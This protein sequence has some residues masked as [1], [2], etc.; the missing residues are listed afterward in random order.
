MILFFFR[1]ISPS[2]PSLLLSPLSLRTSPFPSLPLSEP[3]PLL[4]TLVG[5]PGPL[6]PPR[7]A[8]THRIV[9]ERIQRRLSLVGTLLSLSFKVLRPDILFCRLHHYMRRH[10]MVRA[11]T[12][13]IVAPYGVYM[14]LPF[15][16]LT[17][18][19][20]KI[21]SSS[22]QTEPPKKYARSFFFLVTNSCRYSHFSNP[23]SDRVPAPWPY[24]N[25][26]LKIELP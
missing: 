16:P 8:E 20:I 26:G 11:A 15:C 21:A 1:L 10:F 12:S 6:P 17:R 3:F 7:G 13:D 5:I 24:K 4:P 2:S 25:I 18:Y 9:G 23:P 14:H 22:I 19:S